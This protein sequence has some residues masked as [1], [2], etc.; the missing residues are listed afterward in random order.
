M[1]KKLAGW[2]VDRTAYLKVVLKAVERAL[3][4]VELLAV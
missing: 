1:D 2:T 4:W 3:K